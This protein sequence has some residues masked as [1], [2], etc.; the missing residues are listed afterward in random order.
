MYLRGN[1]RL[2][3]QVKRL[4]IT[5]LDYSHENYL[6]CILLNDPVFQ[7]VDLISKRSKSIEWIMVHR[8]KFPYYITRK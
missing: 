3:Q 6:V 8:Q 5:L 7:K 1:M 4:S 2:L